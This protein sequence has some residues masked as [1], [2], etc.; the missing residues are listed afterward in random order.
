MAGAV[1]AGGDGN[2]EVAFV[3]LG[4]EGGTLHLDPMSSGDELRVAIQVRMGESK[5]SR[6][7]LK[8]F[9]QCCEI[10]KDWN[11]R[12][13]IKTERI[14]VRHSGCSGFESRPELAEIRGAELVVV[15]ER[16]V[17]LGMAPPKAAAASKRFAPQ[18]K[19]LAEMGF[20]DWVRAVELLERYNGRLLRVAN[21]LSEAPA[22][23]SLSPQDRSPSPPSA[24]LP[25]P[26]PPQPEAQRGLQGSFGFCL[27]VQ[28]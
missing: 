27:E 28:G 19:E 17:A 16:L 26:P 20:E 6:I 2:L 23:E 5:R 13:R 9:N 8:L 14:G 18:L 22:E 15:F 21:L 3:C 11:P 1:A 12:P 10:A 4:G 24:P 7:R 25:R